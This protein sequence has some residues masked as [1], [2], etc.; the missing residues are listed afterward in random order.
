[1]FLIPKKLELCLFDGPIASLGRCLG[2]CYDHMLKAIKAIAAHGVFHFVI[3]NHETKQGK[4]DKPPM[5]APVTWCSRT[6][7][8]KKNG[9]NTATC[10]KLQGKV[11]Y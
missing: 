10:N 6:S 11:S 4:C 8:G 9:K 7:Y 3:Q 1:M 2:Q 5:K